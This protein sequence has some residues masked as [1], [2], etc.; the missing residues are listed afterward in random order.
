MLSAVMIVGVG[1]VRRDLG[2]DE[3]IWSWFDEVRRI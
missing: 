3:I 1:M 2:I